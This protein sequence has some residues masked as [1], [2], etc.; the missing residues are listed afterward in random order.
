MKTKLLIVFAFCTFNLFS[1]TN[2]VPN[3]GFETWTNSTTLSDWTIKNNVTQ[4]TSSFT[5]G[6]KSVQ[7]SIA[8]NTTRPEIIAQVPMTAGKTYTVKFKYKDPNGNFNSQHP[9]SLNIKQN[10]SS[11]TISSSTFATDN[12][13][14]VKETTFT[15]DQNMSY[16]LSISLFT[17]DTEAFN[18][19]IDDVQV[20]VQ[21]T[22]QYTLIPDLNFEKKLIELGIDSAP[23]NGKV[24]TNKIN[25]LTSLNVSSS[26]IADLTGIQDFVA[27]ESLDC[28]ENNLTILDL[29][30]NGKLT[31]V[32]CS[33]NQLT[34]FINTSNLNLTHLN[35]DSNQLNSLV[36]S[37]Y[38]VL[39]NLFFNYNKITVIDV[40]SNTLLEKLECYSNL[41][42]EL[43]ITNNTSLIELSCGKN[44]LT[45]LNTSKNLALAY[46]SCSYNQISSLNLYKNT[47]LYGLGCSNNKLST[48][49]ISANVALTGIFCHVNELT[50]LDL[51]R[52][53]VLLLLKCNNNKLL[54]INFKNG[55]NSSIDTNNLPNFKNNPNLKCIQVD[56]AAY[57]NNNWSTLKDATA[58]YNTVCTTLGIEESIFDKIAIYPNPTKGELHIDN[59][60]LEKVTVY[61]ALGKLVKTTTFTSG[62]NDNTIHL[63]GLPKG[64]YYVFLESE[65]ANTAKKIIVE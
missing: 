49:D 48:L 7:L 39:T 6:S 44:Q 25:T 9:I 15:P 18:I 12:N 21:A 63:T 43:N 34:S 41:L 53:S 2:V 59:I 33:T 65:G 28:Q 13:W 19:L 31:D 17:F 38:T 3:G 52:N 24:A 35:C 29:S 5:E 20:F 37:K 32:N 27:L 54:S 61:D 50:S 58:T 56:D 30:K 60:V 42:T 47:A 64:I 55:K 26:S 8:N 45:S 51:S 4:N 11:T 1:Q 62:A 36:V 46:L 57:S 14:T 23:A 22:E 40:S 10:G 16:D